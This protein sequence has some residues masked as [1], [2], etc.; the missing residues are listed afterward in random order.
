M[1][2]KMTKYDNSNVFIE[3]GILLLD[4]RPGHVLH[5]QRSAFLERGVCDGCGYSGQQLAECGQ[6]NHCLT[7]L[8]QL[9]R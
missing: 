8:S 7:S 1:L 3:F 6:T 2:M 5:A 4:T 9:S